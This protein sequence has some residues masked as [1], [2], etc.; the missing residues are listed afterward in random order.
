[1]LCMQ[2]MRGYANAP[3][4]P[5]LGVLHLKHS[6]LDAKTIALHLGPVVHS[7]NVNKLTLTNTW[8]HARQLRAH[9]TRIHM[10]AHARKP[11]PP[12]TTIAR[13]KVAGVLQGALQF[14]SPSRL[15]PPPPPPPP[16]PLSSE[17]P[18]GGGPPPYPPP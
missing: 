11:P 2:C 16:K 8:T 15:G 10:R 12:H 7:Y 4:P 13:A 14:Q 17:P 5:G 9:A 1:M 18:R 3:P 6:L